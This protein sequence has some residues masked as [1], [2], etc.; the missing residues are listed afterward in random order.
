VLAG[1]TEYGPARRSFALP[2][3]L[4]TASIGRQAELTATARHLKDFAALALLF[5]VYL[6]TAKLGLRLDA[7][8]GFAALVWPPSGIALA[9]LL[10]FGKRLWPAITLGAFVVNVTTGAPVLVACGIAAGNTLDAVVGAYLL[11]RVYRFDPSLGS[12]QVM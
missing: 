6:G 10:L 11:L 4:V 7:V 5:A 8:S 2:T 3:R 1:A 12:R 9:T